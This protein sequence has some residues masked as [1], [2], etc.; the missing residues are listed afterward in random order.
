MRGI[1]DLECDSMLIR[2]RMLRAFE[3]FLKLTGSAST[4]TGHGSRMRKHGW[5]PS[6]APLICLSLIFQTSV[7]DMYAMAKEL[8]VFQPDG[9]R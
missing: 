8:R 6:C 5:R 4:M 9:Y 2:I 3:S 7:F 1:C